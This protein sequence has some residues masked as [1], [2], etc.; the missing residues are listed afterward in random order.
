MASPPSISRFAFSTCGNCHKDPHQGKLGAD[1]ESCHVEASWKQIDMQR[2]AHPGL[3]IQAGHAKVQC[4]TCHDRVTW[5]AP[6]VASA[7]P[8]VT[9]RSTRPSSATTAPSVTR[10]SAGWG[11]ARRSVARV[12]DR[13]SYPWRESTKTTALRT[14]A[15]R[16]SCRAPSAS[17]SSSS[18][19]APTATK[20]C[21]RVSLRIARGRVRSPATRWTA[22]APT[23]FGVEL[24]ATSRFALEGGHEAAPCG[25]C[26]T[27][28]K[29]RVEWQVARQSCADCQRQS[30]GT[31]FA[32]EMQ[33]GGCASCH[34]AVSWDIP[35][36]RPRHVA[37][38]RRAHQKA[39][40]DQCHTRATADK[41]A[42][43]G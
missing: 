24:H 33:A 16:R 3:N 1:C 28:K 14:T 5:R 4:R 25:T 32:E 11:A 43:S 35:E 36:H 12:H 37:L 13:T 38:D 9:R 22:F 26:H 29:P 15:T 31:Q 30:H 17:G 19:A 41:R 27:G 39:R 21:T 23:T 18:S 40:C 6:R 20:T 2:S 7:A 34:T 42:G 10:R 8:R